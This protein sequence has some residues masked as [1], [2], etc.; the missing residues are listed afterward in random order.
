MQTTLQKRDAMRRAA[1]HG[2]HR[3][4]LAMARE[5]SWGVK[6]GRSR[7]SRCLRS[8]YSAGG[9]SVL[10]FYSLPSFAVPAARL[11]RLFGR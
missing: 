1:T 9:G 3:T 11:G 6:C 10:M 2:T 4:E 7:N 8:R 5:Q